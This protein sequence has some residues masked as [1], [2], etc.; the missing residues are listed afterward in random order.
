MALLLFVV[1]TGFAVLAAASLLAK[2]EGLRG[3]G[4]IGG[5]VS[6]LLLGLSLL[7]LTYGSNTLPSEYGWLSAV[8]T[9]T[10][11]V[12]VGSGVRKFARRNNP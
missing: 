3:A 5:G 7:M 8:L 6:T 12:T 1:G 10:G 9:F 2:N 4:R 11:L